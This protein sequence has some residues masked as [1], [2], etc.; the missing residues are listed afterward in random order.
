[1]PLDKWFR[2]AIALVAIAAIA[3]GIAHWDEVGADGLS[4]I[5]IAEL[6]MN[7][8]YLGAV[9]GSW[10]PLYPTLTA[11]VWAILG[12][13]RGTASIALHVITTLAALMTIAGTVL[14][15]RQISR[16]TTST[17]QHWFALAVAAWVVL[18]IAPVSLATPDPLLTALLVVATVTAISA[19]ESPSIWKTVAL[20]VLLGLAY[21]T[22]T[23][24]WYF[25]FVQLVL[26]VAVRSEQRRST[27]LLAVAAFILVAVPFVS[28]LSDK[29]DRLT[30][31]DAGR[32][33]MLWNSNGVPQTHFQGDSI[34]GF[35]KHASRIILTNPTVY[36][37]ASPFDVTYPP[38][39][40]PSYWYDGVDP[41]W[42]IAQLT[43]TVTRNVV[44]VLRQT[45][46]LLA[47]LLIII[48]LAWRSGQI[49]SALRQP[50]V[51]IVLLPALACLALY[52]LTHFEGRYLAPFLLLCSI[53]IAVLGARTSIDP[54]IVRVLTAAF[55]LI[56]L[57]PNALRAGRDVLVVA[58]VIESKE[59]PHMRGIA[60]EVAR[61]GL[62]PGDRIGAVGQM[63]RA[64]WAYVAELR[65]IAEVSTDEAEE[66]WELS[67]ERRN[68]VYEAMRRHGATAVVSWDMPDD[69]SE[70]GW[71]RMNSGLFVRRLAP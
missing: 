46:A 41:Q 70:T 38:S 56:V 57:A 39:F 4:Y 54:R 9:S 8:D 19:I 31:G 59:V 1:M 30:V 17:W 26:F 11:I 52:Q 42:S 49:R 44:A 27:R 62:Q 36:E 51:L 22:K 14:L 60:R 58:G 45:Y 64:Y 65:I 21:L 69:V 67:G 13:A 20:G 68:R 61:A 23:I 71:Q 48:A 40:D 15:S 28:A 55:A 53:V 10:S 24:A 43:R 63:Y 6:L 34:H 12:G 2:V 50:E 35:P 25:A 16:A 5:S 7:G 33:S 37:Y 18:E 47:A 3:Q 32:H 29:K 66:F